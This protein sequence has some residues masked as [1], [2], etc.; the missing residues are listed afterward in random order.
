MSSK[1]RTLLLKNRNAKILKIK[2]QQ[3]GVKLKSSIGKKAILHKRLF[4]A[5]L[6]SKILLL[7]SIICKGLL[8]PICL[9]IINYLIGLLT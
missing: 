9:V 5:T 3:R 6:P 2:Y 7:E 8:Q 4:S 1:L